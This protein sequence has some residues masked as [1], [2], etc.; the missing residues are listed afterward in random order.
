MSGISLDYA[1]ASATGI[2]TGTST[3]RTLG[4]NPTIDTGTAPEDVWA[5]AVLGTL[6]GID[7][8][9]I[10]RPQNVAVNMELVSSSALDTAVGTGARTVFIAYLDALYVAKTVTLTLN[11]TAPVALPEPVMRI[12]GMQVV[13]NGTFG[14][15]NLG[16]LSIRAVG[17]TGATY[18]YA[19]IG[20]GTA[21]SSM[22]T[23]PANTTLDV[24]SLILSVN[25]TNAWA[26][27]SL[28]FQTA[29]GRILKGIELSA[30]TSSPYR[31]EAQHAPV[32]VV[33]AQTDI[34]W[35]CETVSVNATSVT[36]GLIGI[37][38]PGAPFAGLHGIGH[39]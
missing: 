36:G 13:T 31:H 11:G 16:N 8:R 29:A 22:Y 27:F 38:R 2:F 28:C 5:G 37:L 18:S 17:G 19:E 24:L 3:A 1:Y 34:W 21:R 32:T 39:E 33:A 25:K 4:N 15:A 23:V 6:N 30:S 14:S 20:D 7:H 9:L 26:T 35:R 10:P 12:N